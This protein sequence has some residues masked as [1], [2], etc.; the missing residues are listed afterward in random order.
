MCS[1]LINW[2]NKLT[3]QDNTLCLYVADPATFHLIFQSLFLTLDYFINTVKIKYFQKPHSAPLIQLWM[4]SLAD[5]YMSLLQLCSRVY[6][7]RIVSRLNLAFNCH[8][9]DNPF[10]C[11]LCDI[12]AVVLRHVP[13]DKASMP[14]NWVCVILMTGHVLFPPG[15]RWRN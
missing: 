6:L 2:L 3:L 1:T 12:S 15:S 11:N 9:V 8:R 13:P 10:I 7:P 14:K 4:G 5:A